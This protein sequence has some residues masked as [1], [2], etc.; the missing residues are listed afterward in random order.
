MV[1]TSRC[2]LYAGDQAADAAQPR[3]LPLQI[4]DHAT[5]YLPP[6]PQTYLNTYESG[7]GELV[8]VRH[9]AQLARTPAGWDRPSVPPGTSPP[10]WP[11]MVS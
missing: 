9:S 4:P 5:G 10:V 11:A 6:D 7:F 2:G 1:A 3:P 8:A